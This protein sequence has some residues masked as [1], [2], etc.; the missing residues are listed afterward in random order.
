M[1][2]VFETMDAELVRRVRAAAQGAKDAADEMR[3]KVRALLDLCRDRLLA[4]I[5]GLQ[6]QAIG[7]RIDQ[8][9]RIRQARGEPLLGLA[10]RRESS[11]VCVYR[12]GLNHWL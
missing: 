5:D 7:R 9:N 4:C 3:R 11:N 6:D 10:T 1:R 12:K 2:A 8:R